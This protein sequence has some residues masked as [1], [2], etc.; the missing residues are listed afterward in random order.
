[1]TRKELKQLIREV[2]SEVEYGDSYEIEGL[3]IRFNFIVGR[4]LIQYDNPNR[5]NWIEAAVEE[6]EYNKKTDFLRLQG[7]YSV[8]VDNEKKQ[9]Q[10]A[11]MMK[12][13]VKEGKVA[14][15]QTTGDGFL[16]GFWQNNN[17]Y[18]NIPDSEN[19][20]RGGI[21]SPIFIPDD[22]ATVLAY[23]REELPKNLDSLKFKNFL[24][25]LGQKFRPTI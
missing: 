23:L 21:D 6:L 20:S 13:F 4:T 3:N 24:G 12:N 18:D 1:M 11:F 9:G 14:T 19:K 17:I 22:G 25:K 10:F 8:E 16:R 15:A 2:I 5:R 7:R